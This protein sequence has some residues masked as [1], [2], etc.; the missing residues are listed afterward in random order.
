MCDL[1]IDI[2]A[3]SVESHEVKVEVYT[4]EYVCPVED[5]LVECPP[6]EDF[7]NECVQ[8]SDCAQEY[9]GRGYKCC[10]DSCGDRFCEQPVS[11]TV[12]RTETGLGG[13]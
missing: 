2:P 5:Q 3:I 1:P 8:D 6:E 7:L 9:P 4:T 10:S 13:I 12:R 11:R